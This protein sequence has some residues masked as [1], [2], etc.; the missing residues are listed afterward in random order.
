[1]IA[2]VKGIK[3]NKIINSPSFAKIKIK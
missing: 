3:E 2:K 1:L